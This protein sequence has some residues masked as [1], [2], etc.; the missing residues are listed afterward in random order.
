MNNQYITIICNNINYGHMDGKRTFFHWL[1]QIAAIKDYKELSP[2][3]V[4][5]YID[6]INIDY[7]QLLALWD[8]FKVYRIKDR[9]LVEKLLHYLPEK[10]GGFCEGIFFRR[11]KI[12]LKIKKYGRNKKIYLENDQ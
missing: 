3:E 4:H 11:H 9:E 2:R 7:D 12:K 5:L 6:P 8:L 1:K 10:T